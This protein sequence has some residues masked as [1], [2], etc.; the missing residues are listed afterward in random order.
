MIFLERIY[1][2][3]V[4]EVEGHMIRG[5]EVLQREG[6]VV[7][8]LVVQTPEGVQTVQTAVRILVAV[9]AVV[10]QT[11]EVGVQGEMVEQVS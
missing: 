4:E 10:L 1:I 3:R 8:V 2:T 9:V 7:V 11:V 5:P 6:W